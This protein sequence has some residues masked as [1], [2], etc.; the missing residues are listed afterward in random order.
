MEE[1][2]D[3]CDDPPASRE[4]NC[5]VEELSI[6]LDER[7]GEEKGDG[8]ELESE[9]ESSIWTQHEDDTEESMKVA[10]AIEKS[11]FIQYIQKRLEEMGKMK[12]VGIGLSLA[13]KPFTKGG[14]SALFSNLAAFDGVINR[15][16]DLITLWNTLH[17]KLCEGVTLT[18]LKNP[19]YIR[20][21]FINIFF[22]KTGWK[23]NK[24]FIYT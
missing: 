14:K 5:E 9:Y 11:H 1:I 23:K 20:D 6:P 16:T 21:P 2:L 13:I 8:S 19:G 15:E 3:D 24:Q 10:E 12:N 4:D 7:V 17:M 18:T 22:Q